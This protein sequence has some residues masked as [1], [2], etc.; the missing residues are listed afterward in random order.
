[1]NSVIERTDYSGAGCRNQT[2]LVAPPPRPGETVT[3]RRNILAEQRV[4]LMSPAQWRD[5]MER[6]S[7]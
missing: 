3:A 6:E 2:T 7:G 4:G 1:V 5:E